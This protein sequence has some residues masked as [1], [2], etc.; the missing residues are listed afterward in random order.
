MF[1]ELS[2]ASVVFVVLQIVFLMVVV[3]MLG[4]DCSLFVSMTLLFVGWLV[5]FSLRPFVGGGSS[6]REQAAFRLLSF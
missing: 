5:V 2:S 3:E 6:I 1:W 4:G